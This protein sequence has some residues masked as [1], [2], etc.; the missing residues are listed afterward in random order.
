MRQDA[1]GYAR[2]CEALADAPPAAVERIEA[3]ALLVTGDE[4]T[5]APPQAVRAMAERLH[6]RQHARGSAAA[7]RPLDADR[8]ARRMRCAS[9]ATSWRR[10]AETR[11]E[12]AMAD[13][14][15]TNVRIF[16]GCGDQPY[17]GD[18][19]VQGNRIS[20]VVRTGY[21]AR[22]TSPVIG[23]QVVDGA[24]AFLMPGMVEAHTHFSWNNQPRLDAI[25]RMPPEEHIL[26]CAEVAK[27][28]LDMGW[29]CASAPP[30]PS[31]GST[32]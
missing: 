10:N 12:L 14:L 19:L 7:L 4:D 28:Y 13:V 21:G 3:P 16:D 29:T 23:A 27:L 5:V 2:S 25:Q 31:L 30:P 18:V 15:F 20:R 8:A 9:C 11:A 17:S 6:T 1:D 26:W 24:G 32:W 22:G